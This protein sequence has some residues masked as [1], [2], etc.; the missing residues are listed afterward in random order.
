VDGKILEFVPKLLSLSTLEAGVWSK[1]GFRS[2]YSWL[3][4]M[5]VCILSGW[6]V[7]VAEKTERY[8]ALEYP[9]LRERVCMDYR[10]M[11]LVSTIRVSFPTYWCLQAK[12]FIAFDHIIRA[13]FWFG[14]WVILCTMLWPIQAECWIVP[15]LSYYRKDKVAI[16]NIWISW[17]APVFVCIGLY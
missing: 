13:L 11:S 5:V 12:V 2:Y 7:S 15:A 16:W 3:E 17:I 9:L 10:W 1:L 14:L 8:L 6:V 4:G